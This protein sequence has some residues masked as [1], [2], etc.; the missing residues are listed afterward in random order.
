MLKI[1]LNSTLRYKKNTLAPFFVRD[2]IRKIDMHCSSPLYFWYPRVLYKKRGSHLVPVIKFYVSILLCISPQ[3]NKKSEQ[4]RSYYWIQPERAPRKKESLRAAGG[5]GGE[6]DL[7]SPR[8]N[9]AN[10]WM[11]G[12]TTFFLPFLISWSDLPRGH[13]S[14]SSSAST[15]WCTPTQKVI[16]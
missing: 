1:T 3:K 7:W 2:L 12:I 6:D 5:G 15:T 11:L 9:V 10:I 14:T 8:K 16:D 4:H 13:F